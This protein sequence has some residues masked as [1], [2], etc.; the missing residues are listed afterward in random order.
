MNALTSAFLQLGHSPRGHPAPAP[1]SRPCVPRASRPVL[2]HPAHSFAPI[3]LPPIH[4]P[5]PR[6]SQA[7]RPGQRSASRPG[8]GLQRGSGEVI[9][10]KESGQGKDSGDSTLRQRW[11]RRCEQ[12]RCP[13]GPG[14]RQAALALSLLLCVVWQTPDAA[15]QSDRR[16]RRQSGDA[17]AALAATPAS[18]PTT[19]APVPADHSL[20]GI[21]NDPEFTRRLLGSYGFLADREPRLTT[22]E[23]VA[24]RDTIL[25][26]LREDPARAVPALEK[27]ITPQASAL[28]D[29]TLGTIRFQSED[30]T[31]AVRHYEAALA[32]FPDFLRAQRNLGLALVREGRYAEAIPALTR[33]LTLGAA[34]GRLYGL[35]A[36]SQ[37]QQGHFLSATAAYQQALLYEPENLDFLLGLVKCHVATAN[38]GV[39]LAL[40]DELL[41]RHPDRDNLWSLQANIYVQ[42]NQLAKAAVNYEILRQLG[43][44]SAAHLTL[45]GDLYVSEGVPELALAAYL[46]AARLDGGTNLTRT[47]RAA[48]ILVSRG[49]WDEARQLFAKVRD[50]AGGSL[51][52]DDELK[53]LRLEA[54]VAL[55]T[56]A[57]DQAI[58]TLERILIR[59]PLDGETLLLAGDHYKQAGDTER[60]ALRYDAAAKLEG[61]EASALVKHAQ[62]LVETQRYP[63]AIELLR[64]AQKIAPRE[65]VQRYLERVE[66][67]A[68]RARG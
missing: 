35:L 10:A 43:K 38:Y 11:L 48:D 20:A 52:A 61:F 23:Q 59:N 36:F 34:D 42:Q 2:P 65:Q 53:L 40:L 57:G 25:P 13:A 31:N 50:L 3:P 60:A 19:F 12:R 17:S 62:L 44:A 14:L 6:P 64:R 66:Q 33:T 56:G 39:A 8:K 26:L 32:K 29:Y 27:L 49:A 47:L 58:Q 16:A 30:F 22:E 7:D 24:Y 68:A 67:V 18:A 9:R 55:A 1:R 21:W 28:F 45:L 37:V 63:Q 4:F 51:A 54:R 15:A 46:D 41:L 5:C